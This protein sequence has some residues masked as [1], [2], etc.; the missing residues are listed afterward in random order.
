MSEFLLS[1]FLLFACLL[2]LPWVVLL[3]LYLI[4]P[5]VEAISWKLDMRRRRKNTEDHIQRCHARGLAWTGKEWV[6]K[7]T[8]KGGGD[9]AG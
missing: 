3:F 2:M 5:F 4:K 8:S 6:A 9:D 7:D 1:T